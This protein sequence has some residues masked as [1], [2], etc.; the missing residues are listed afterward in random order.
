MKW[1]YNLSIKVKILSFFAFILVFA[2]S[3]GIFSIKNL[4][5][6][7]QEAAE[8]YDNWLPRVGL[9][10]A[11]RNTFEEYRIL[12][13]AH[14]MSSSPEAMIEEE[15]AMAGY[16]KDMEM[17]RTLYEPMVTPGYEA[18][19][20]QKFLENWELYR[21]ISQQKL[22]P[23]SRQSRQKEAIAL[24][25]GESRVEYHKARALARDL[26]DYNTR[27][28]KKAVD[29]GAVTYASGTMFITIAVA[30]VA[31]ICLLV[32][33]MIIVTVSAPIQ[34]LTEI[35]E[36]LASH[37]LTAAVTGAERRDEIGAMA[38]AVQL[39]KD[40]LIKT[41]HL[42]A[43]HTIEQAEKQRRV[44]AIDRLL[45]GFDDA[46]ISAPHAVSA[47]PSERDANSQVT[48]VAAATE[49]MANSLS[50][51][52]F[53]LAKPTKSAG[54][55]VDEVGCTN[56]T[57]RW[58]AEA[59]QKIGEVVDVITSI[60]SQTNL[61][62]L[63]ATIEAAQAGEENKGF[64]VVAN[65]VKNLASQT[66][67]ATDEIASQIV[68]IQEA[69]NG[70]VRAITGIGGA[71]TEIGSIATNIAAAVEEQGTTTAE[72]SRTVQQAASGA[73]EVSD[74]LSQ[75]TQT[76]GEAGAAAGEMTRAVENP[77]EQDET[78]QAEAEHFLS[79]VK[80]V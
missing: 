38:R 3:I 36:R 50:E 70:A 52:D 79:A 40:D 8:V 77:A 4:S 15:K 28:G 48:T 72:I 11:I 31:L 43:V 25:R 80:N 63:N 45:R 5:A 27:N 18:A 20:Y 41:N 44:E 51:I 30:L 16:L 69:T 54:K 9:I 39:F 74:S 78:L 32:G 57:V 33:W 53:Q 66:A 21:R 6:F 10:N 37:D 22:L 55:A 65:T 7:N 47:A 60:A 62:A 73:Q 35:M 75:V 29:R 42:V 64:A 34:N 67:K 49:A 71:I 56:E 76:A 59:A 17:Q 68:T 12:E 24:F 26:V 19:T 2:I 58:L 61:L 14:I 46:S 1:L 13:G 23:L